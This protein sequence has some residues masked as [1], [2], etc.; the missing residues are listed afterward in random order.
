MDHACRETRNGNMD[1]KES[2]RHKG[3]AF[4]NAVETSQ[5]EAACLVLQMP[6]T[7]MSREVV[8]L[9]T[10]HPDKRTYL[11]KNYVTLKEMHPEFDDIQ[12]HNLLSEY[13]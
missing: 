7:R 1:L 11:L 12:S 13:E 3:N 5:Q 6:I 4:L 10:S 9:Q 8:F 2:V